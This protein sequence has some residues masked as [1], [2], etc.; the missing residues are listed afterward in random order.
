MG[1][2]HGPNT[3]SRVDFGFGG[4]EAAIK[5]G[6]KIGEADG[7]LQAVAREKGRPIATCRSSGLGFGVY[8][9][10]LNPIYVYFYFLGVHV[11]VLIMSRY[12]VSEMLE[13]LN[14]M[15]EVVLEQTTPKRVQ[16]RRAMLVRRRTVHSMQAEAGSEP[17]LLTLRLRT[18]A[19]T[20]IK[21]SASI[22]LLLSK[23]MC[24]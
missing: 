16:H 10:T 21:A 22:S 7:E 24:V 8:M 23:A 11:Y 2:P 9:Y 20:Y 4:H 6:K 15:T 1:L 3:S 12:G 13:K 19:G 14:G 18:Q 5:N 17:C